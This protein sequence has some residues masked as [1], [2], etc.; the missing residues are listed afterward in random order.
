MVEWSHLAENLRRK[1]IP[2]RFRTICDNTCAAGNVNR[3]LA[4]GLV[5][6][7]RCVVMRDDDDFHDQ[8]ALPLRKP[9]VARTTLHELR[10]P[11]H[12]GA[13]LA[14]PS[15]RGGTPRRT[16]VPSAGLATSS[17]ALWHEFRLNVPMRFNAMK[18]RGHLG[19]PLPP[20]RGAIAEKASLCGPPPGATDE[21]HVH[22]RSLISVAWAM[23]IQARSCAFAATISAMIARVF[24]SQALGLVARPA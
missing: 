1:R 21:G 15:C 20:P 11:M 6:R 13:R 24:L 7:C 19:C 18:A 8:D 2:N 16:S 12:Y 5:T 9:S 3:A 4:F 22:A 10:N 17:A 14:P 23:S